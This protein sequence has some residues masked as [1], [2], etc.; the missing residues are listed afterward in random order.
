MDLFTA[1]DT[2]ASA[3]KLT[4]P[5]PSETHLQRI[6]SAAVRAP[7][8]GKLAPWR[9]VVLAGDTRLLLGQAM[10]ELLRAERP[11]C[12]AAQLSAERDKPL[13]APVVVAVAAQTLP[14][15]KVPVH[16]QVHAV[17]AAV[18]NMLLAAHALGYGA[19]WKTGTAARSALVKR[20]L[21]LAD[22][23]EIVAFVYLGTVAVAGPVR[24]ATLDGKVRWL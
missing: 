17:A 1:I 5:G 24:P 4:D 20:A 16:E 15:H 9:F 2:R 23:D 10:A 21:A 14:G 3:L 7:D 8:H 12:S 22:N 18:Q 11:D 6:L 19:M 13:R